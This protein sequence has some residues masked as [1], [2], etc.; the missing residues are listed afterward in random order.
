M[1]VM[2]DI[3]AD[4]VVVGSVWFVFG[5]HMEVVDRRDRYPGDTEWLNGHLRYIPTVRL[6]PLDSS[7]K[8]MK[9]ERVWVAAWRIL[10][11]GAPSEAFSKEMGA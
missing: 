8:R 1:A 10:N 7:G 5:K 3:Q 6:C 2:R 11:F 9:P 4:A